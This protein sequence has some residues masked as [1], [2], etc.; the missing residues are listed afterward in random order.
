M[1]SSRAPGSFEREP[2]TASQVSSI[3]A[4][5]PKIVGTVANLRQMRDDGNGG[6]HVGTVNNAP[7]PSQAAGAASGKR[8]PHDSSHGRDSD[9]DEQV[10]DLLEEVIDDESQG[11]IPLNSE[12]SRKISW[13]CGACRYCVLAIDH[14]G[15]PLPLTTDAWGNP[16]P[17]QCPRCMLSHTKWTQCVPFDDHGDHVNVKGA[18]SNSANR[19]LIQ[20]SNFELARLQEQQQ[21][22]QQQ[23]AAGGVGAPGGIAPSQAPTAGGQPTVL[24]NLPA[25]LQN[26]GLVSYRNGEPMPTTKPQPAPRKQKLAYYCGPCGRKLLRMDQY[27]DLVPLDKDSD[28]RTLP[29]MCP[30]CKTMHGD[31]LIRPF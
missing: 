1:K 12:E 24:Q 31:W 19:R 21:K 8:L 28:G 6:G 16:I 27:G 4:P 13:Q 15:K 20:E 14:R 17:L 30:G 11:S 9:D 10:E 25:I 29:L 3:F 22:H 18:F 5:P 7:H 26:I 2:S 23:Q